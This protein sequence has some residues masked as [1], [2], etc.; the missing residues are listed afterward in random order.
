MDIS[1]SLASKILK[2]QKRC[3]ALIKADTGIDCHDVTSE[4]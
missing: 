1:K 3:Q 2:K 4:V